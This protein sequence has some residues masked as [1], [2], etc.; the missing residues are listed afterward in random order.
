M[1]YLQYTSMLSFNHYIN[2]SK[3]FP[4]RVKCILYF[5]VVFCLQACLLLAT[6]DAPTSSCPQTSSFPG[7]PVY[8]YLTY[9]DDWSEN[10]SLGNFLLYSDKELAGIPSSTGAFH[11]VSYPSR[12]LETLPTIYT[13]HSTFMPS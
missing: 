5:P 2:S 9:S 3:T 11:L 1:I 4:K 6:C 10:P 13:G 8:R 12:S 7:V